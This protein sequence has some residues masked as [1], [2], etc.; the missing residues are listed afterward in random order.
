MH[1]AILTEPVLK[2]EVD[3]YRAGKLPERLPHEQ[4]CADKGD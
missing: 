2:A 4:H 1:K 3:A